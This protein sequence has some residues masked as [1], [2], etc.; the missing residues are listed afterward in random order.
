M[1]R[2]GTMTPMHNNTSC[3][4]LQARYEGP[5]AQK[6]TNKL[7]IRI[8]NGLINEILKNLL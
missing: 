6:T 4:R 5:M 1:N 8:E 7:R 2:L 3:K